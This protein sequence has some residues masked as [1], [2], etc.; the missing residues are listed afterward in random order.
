MSFWVYLEDHTA[1]PWCGFKDGGCPEPCYPNIQVDRHEE[2]GTYVLG[3]NTDAELNITH[4]YSPYYY[5]YLDKEKGLRVLDH[6]RAGDAIPDLE[7]AVSVLGTTRDEDY[8]AKIEGN[9]GAP[10]ALLLAWARQYPDAI[11]RVS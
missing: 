3:G 8:W 1:E 2:G 4:N 6:A 7:R 11:F 5:E 10:L 9:A